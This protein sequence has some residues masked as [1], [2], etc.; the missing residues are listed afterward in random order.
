MVAPPDDDFDHDPSPPPQ[1]TLQEAHPC[2]SVQSSF[3]FLDRVSS[4]SQAGAALTSRQRMG[5][6]LG[7]DNRLTRHA[8]LIRL[9]THRPLASACGSCAMSTRIQSKPPV[10]VSRR[11]SR[12]SHPIH[13]IPSSGCSSTQPS[14]QGNRDVPSL[15]ILLVL[16]Y[17]GGV[18]SS[19]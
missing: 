2:S 10:A 19:I 7:Q 17:A 3:H 18:S 15:T 11:I 14:R 1:L 6:Q 13:S 16:R 9:S 12:S 4:S 5:F 8:D